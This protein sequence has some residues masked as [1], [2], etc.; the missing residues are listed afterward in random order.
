MNT[1]VY[2]NLHDGAVLSPTGNFSIDLPIGEPPVQ[3][4]RQV[5]FISLFT[6][7]YADSIR[8][9]KDD[10]KLH[11]EFI[12]LEFDANQTTAPDLVAALTSIDA[13]TVAVRLDN[14]R[15]IIKVHL[16]PDK[17]TAP[18][19]RLAF[20][21]FDE[22]QVSGEPTEV[23]V[24]ENGVAELENEYSASLFALRLENSA[25]ALVPLEPKDL[26]N[27][28][29]EHPKTADS[30]TLDGQTRTVAINL[31]RQIYQIQFTSASSIPS[32]S[33]LEFYR[34][35]LDTPA[36][37]PTVSADITNR[38][39]T[40]SDEFIDARFAV[41]IKQSDDA[42]RHRNYWA[43]QKVIVR[44]YPS[45]PRIGI[46]DPVELIPD[47]SSEPSKPVYFWQHPGQ[48]S[49]IAGIQTPDNAG[50]KLAKDLQRYLDGYFESLKEENRTNGSSF[51]PPD[52]ITVALVIESDAPCEFD[53]I[54][55]KVSYQLA[56]ANAFTSGQD[57]H[58]LRFTGEGVAAE[59]ITIAQP[60]D[61]TVTSARL[62][63]VE[64]FKPH[65]VLTDKFD[66]PGDSIIAE[67]AGA[68][69]GVEKWAAQPIRPSQAI[70]VSGVRMGLLVL[71][72]RTELQ[73]EIR[74]DWRGLPQ[75]KQITEAIL[76]P[77]IIG[78]KHWA[79]LRFA[80]SVDLFEQPFWLLCRATTGDAVWL[81]KADESF[82][83]MLRHSDEEQSDVLEGMTALYEWMIPVKAQVNHE[84]YLPFRLK[85]DDQIVVP[86]LTED[87]TQIHDI[88][89]AL[90]SRLQTAANGGGCLTVKL[91]FTASVEG[92]IT[93]YP[94]KIE[95][96]INKLANLPLEFRK[97]FPVELN[98]PPD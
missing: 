94:P 34:M 11:V 86:D 85:V 51:I 28:I 30:D 21:N 71:S 26:F 95:Y 56:S 64:S 5:L 48:F 1:A 84:S 91:S 16:S 17:V 38:T 53:L 80:E 89:G 49:D 18:G 6:G 54:N 76:R 31:P 29:G 40:L 79:N 55:L 10:T 87:D 93:V 72:E 97:T 45:G 60:V 32:G 42:Y 24:V 12:E 50:E 27:L 2:S 15:K 57:K 74:E 44:S 73:I 7:G 46:V 63:T 82:I 20:H 58:V 3:H 67:N 25:G 62:R 96:F 88:T 66:E 43:I 33:R 59:Q 98:D 65:S 61:T 70:S 75:G 19:Y 90:N 68:Y 69:I 52:K 8:I 23:V 77:T 39:A 83:C 35:D 9:E 14:S 92:I 22:D 13:E 37:K 4:Y 36:D 41:R 78:K 47:K 81:A